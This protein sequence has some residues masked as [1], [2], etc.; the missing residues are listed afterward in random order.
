MAQKLSTIARWLGLIRVRNMVP[1]TVQAQMAIP[2]ERPH[3]FQR[4]I[5]IAAST[6]N[7]ATMAWPN[8]TEG[9]SLQELLGP[10]THRR[11]TNSTRTPVNSNITVTS[12]FEYLTNALMIPPVEFP[13]PPAGESLQ[14]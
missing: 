2:S 8:G 6:N 4:R 5:P 14:P 1:N 3:G 7:V 10:K 9:F 11:V 13:W 12:Q